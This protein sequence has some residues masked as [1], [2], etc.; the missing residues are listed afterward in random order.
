MPDEFKKEAPALRLLKELYGF[1]LAPRLW[2]ASSYELK[3]L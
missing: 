3:W 1:K 2:N